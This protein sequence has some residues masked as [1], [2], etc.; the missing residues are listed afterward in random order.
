L[1]LGSIGL[2]IL[3]LPMDSKIATPHKQGN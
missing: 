3:M 2:F 1:I